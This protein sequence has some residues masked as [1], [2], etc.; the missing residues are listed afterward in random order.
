MTETEGLKTVTEA[1]LLFHKHFLN[2]D[3]KGIY[4]LYAYSSGDIAV[5]T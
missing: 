1:N 4:G 5:T 3:T 2:A